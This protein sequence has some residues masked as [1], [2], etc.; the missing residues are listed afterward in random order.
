[1]AC[2]R[3]GWDC[4][5]IKALGQQMRPSKA[6]ASHTHSKRL[7]VK[8]AERLAQLLDLSLR[9]VLLVLR[10]GQLLGHLIEVAENSFEH[11]LDALDF[12][13]RFE[14]PSALFGR[15]IAVTPV[16]LDFGARR[17]SAM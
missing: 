2:H 6:V 12:S 4:R 10:L 16:F 5:I 3:F 8:P 1:M 7:P 13:L 11:F 9:Y 17:A 14:N 15:Q